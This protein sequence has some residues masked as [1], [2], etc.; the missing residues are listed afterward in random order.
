MK[1]VLLG[2]INCIA[3][4]SCYSGIIEIKQTKVSSA[5]QAGLPCLPRAF[6]MLQ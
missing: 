3:T 1:N 5:E 6:G 4:C 2:K